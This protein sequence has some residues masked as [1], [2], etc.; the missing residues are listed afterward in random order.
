MPVYPW[1]VG[2]FPIL[3]LYAVNFGSVIDREVPIS[4]FLLFTATTIAFGIINFALRNNHKTALTVTIIVFGFSLSGHV[5]TLLFETELLVFWSLAVLIAIAAAIIGLHKISTKVDL[6][7]AAIPLNLISATLI[8]LQVVTLIAR[9]SESSIAQLAGSFGGSD[10]VRQSSARIHESDQRPDIYYI[11]PDA[12]PSNGWLEHTVNF[13][14][15]SFTEALRTRGFD[16]IPHAQSNYGATLPSLAS[17]LNMQYFSTNPT[18]LH[19]VDYLRLSIANSDVAR[20]LQQLGY[21]YIQLLSG[22]LMPSSIADIN[23]D[24]TPNGTVDVI[25]D[26][27]ALT[28]TLRDTMRDSQTSTHMRRLYQKSFLSLYMDTTLLKVFG[29]ELRNWLEGNFIGPY[30]GGSPRRFLATVDEI[31]SVVSMPEATFTIIHMLKPHRPVYFDETGIINKISNPTDEEFIASLNF[32][33]ARYLD[34]IDAILDGSEHEPV[35]IFQADHG[36][37]KGEVRT[38]QWR[39][40]HF[41]VFSA[42][43]VPARYPIEIPRPHTNINTFPLILN[44]VFDAGFEHHESRLFEL[45]KSNNRPFAQEEVTKRYAHGYAS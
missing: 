7:Q 13:D 32:V 19:A 44:A 16:V 27:E 39:T 42:Y 38:E 31:D 22:Y 24:F 35:I 41:D 23:R 29:G 40:I 18:E 9:H 8:L 33:N 36:S 5:H 1:L 3:H 28:V 6:K 17:T 25:M 20:Y 34:M 15:A 43:Y 26:D 21:T 2:A 14:N 4:I 37:T 11:I 10:A 30:D 45:L 12:Y